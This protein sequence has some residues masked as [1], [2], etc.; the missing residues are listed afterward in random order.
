MHRSFYHYD[1]H[2][3]VH[4]IDC[5][6]TL[7]LATG[8]ARLSL[9]QRALEAAAR[10]QAVARMLIDFSTTVWESDDTHRELSRATRRDFGLNADNPNLRAAMVHPARVGRVADNEHWFATRAAALAWLCAQ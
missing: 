8:L 7:D 1:A 6:G 9:L 3:E 10:S 5:A 4:F 2:L